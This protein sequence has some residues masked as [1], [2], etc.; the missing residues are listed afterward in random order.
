MICKSTANICRD[1]YI[2]NSTLKFYK[3]YPKPL[4]NSDPT[5]INPI[6]RSICMNGHI[7]QYI[8]F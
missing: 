4:K 7:V 8:S 5:K 3:T 1:I 6:K 2:S